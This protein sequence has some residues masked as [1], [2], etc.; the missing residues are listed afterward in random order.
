M[1]K[2]QAQSIATSL[3]RNLRVNA[4]EHHATEERMMEAANYPNLTQH[5]AHHHTIIDMFEDYSARHENGDYKVYVPLLY[6]LRDWHDD[7]LLQYDRE[8]ISHLAEKH[9]S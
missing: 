5:R 1:L 4:L 7:H 6:A 3:F 2:G 8:Y 9:F